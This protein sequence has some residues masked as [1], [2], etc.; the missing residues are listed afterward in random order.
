MHLFYLHGFASTASSTKAAFLAERFA[1]YGCP[2]HV[3]DF[4][5]PAFETLTTTRMIGQVRAAIDAL[6]PGPVV[7]IGSSL[8]AFVAWHVTADAEA[9]GRPPSTARCC[10]HQPSTSASVA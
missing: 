9:E 7:L 2:L 6:P 1:R 3:P 4:N 10:W 5:A 8:G